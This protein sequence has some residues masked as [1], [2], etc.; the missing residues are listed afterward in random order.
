MT[1]WTVACQAP[2]VPG[3]LQTRILEWVTIPFSRE[4]P[5]QGVEPT[6]P[7]LQEDSLPSEPPGMGQGVAGLLLKL[8]TH[9]YIEDIVVPDKKVRKGASN[10]LS[11]LSLCFS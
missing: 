4:L 5:D 11:T 10:V 8:S 6:S 9:H 3:I 1:P 7:A 2:L